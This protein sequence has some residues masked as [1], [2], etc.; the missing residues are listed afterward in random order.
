MQMPGRH[1]FATESGVWH[2]SY[3]F[4]IPPYLFVDHRAGNT[5]L[6][7][8]ASQTIELS[9]GF[10]TGAGSDNYVA[11]I[12][13]S[14]SMATADSAYQLVANGYRYGFNGKEKDDEVKGEGNQVDYGERAYDSRI[15]RWLS[16]DPLASKYPGV[17]PYVY[18]RN[19]PIVKY[20][21]DGKTD[22]TAT[23]KSQKN[24][25][26][27]VTKTVTVDI[28]YATINLSSREVYNA[29][30]VAGDQNADETFSTSF[31]GKDQ[32]GKD[33]NVNVVTN[34]HYR[35]VNNIN[36]VRK[37]ENIN[38]IV[39]D[40]QNSPSE[41]SVSNPVGVATLGGNVMAMEYAY[42]SDRG[43][44]RHEQ[45]HNLGFQFNDNPA[46]PSHSKEGYMNAHSATGKNTNVGK[47]SANIIKQVFS[48]FLYW[49][50]GTFPAS[51]TSKDSKSQAQ[52]F[53]NVNNLKYDKE[54]AKKAG[55]E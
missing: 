52:E 21:P 39:D 51:R 11:Y 33:I 24:K 29:N 16:L 3:A 22:Y 12:A 18:V 53:I 46:D 45:G 17:S 20:D 27:S 31:L 19:S 48:N 37:G 50:D 7:Y 55:V 38:F 5:P 49:N 41:R 32:K 14:A 6:E 42:L 44:V 1:G 25:N 47:T 30:Q 10:L 13:D 15:G 35:L 23:V 9:N 40:V 2:G 4:S 43:L 8:V 54:K 34:V 36:E 26:G 28:V